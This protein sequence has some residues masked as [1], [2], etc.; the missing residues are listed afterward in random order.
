MPSLSGGVRTRCGAATDVIEHC[1]GAVASVELAGP[2]G[3]G[4]KAAEEGIV[5]A[6]AND[7]LY[8]RVN[9]T[10]LY[11]QAVLPVGD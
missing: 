6:E 5:G 2:R 8:Q 11:E 4:P 3:T 7:G 1:R 9:R 10:G